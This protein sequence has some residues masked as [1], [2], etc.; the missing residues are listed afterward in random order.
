MKPGYWL[1][2]P[3]L[4][5]AAW[6]LAVPAARTASSAVPKAV[7]ATPRRDAVPSRIEQTITDF[8]KEWTA[9]EKAKAEQDASA[10]PADADGLQK[11]IT[12]LLEELQTLGTQRTGPSGQRDLLPDDWRRYIAC[13]A[14]L[15]EATT[16][17]GALS[18][19]EGIAWLLSSAPNL[20]VAY[21]AGWASADPASA[22]DRVTNSKISEPCDCATLMKL[23]EARAGNNPDALKAACATVPWELFGSPTLNPGD[24]LRMAQGTN[25]APWLDSGTAR[26]LAERGMN[27]DGLF[28]SWATARPDEALA[29]WESWPDATIPAELLPMARSNRLVETLSAGLD[30]DSSRDSMVTALERLPVAERTKIT[31]IL[32]ERPDGEGITYGASRIMKAYPLLAP[33]ATGSR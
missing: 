25:P 20:R 31:A 18:K 3:L 11:L 16:R 1:I 19:G 12:S 32:L 24:H 23:L 2:P 27:I 14:R 7:I 30:S 13:R 33:A 5:L 26:S 29:S 22:F 8:H 17:L 10:Y 28:R 9:R 4:G 6:A 15:M 21:M